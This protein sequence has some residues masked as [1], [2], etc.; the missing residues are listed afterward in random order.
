MNNVNGCFAG[1][2]E[3]FIYAE[4]QSIGGFSSP[5]NVTK[6]I[7]ELFVS[8][9]GVKGPRIY[10]KLTNPDAANFAHNGQTFG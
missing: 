9:L 3:P 6:P 1:K 10:V 7:T 4:L 2:T 8:Q 5:N